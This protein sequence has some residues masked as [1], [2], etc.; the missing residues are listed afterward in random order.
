M[1]LFKYLWAEFAKVFAMCFAGLMTIY[2]VIDFFEKLRRFMKFDAH[3]IDILHY[4]ALRMP[5]I[6][7]QIAP[8]AVLMATLLAFGLLTRNRE[9]TAMRACGVSLL[10]I[11]SPF[12]VF[13]VG[14]SIVL[15][16]MS[17]V[18]IPIA[19]TSAEY[20]RNVTIEKK[21]PTTMKATRPWLQVRGPALLNVDT[22]EVGGRRLQGVRLYRLSPEFRLTGIVEA[23]WADYTEIDSTSGSWTLHDGLE[24]RF[25]PDGT[26]DHRRFDSAPLPL[27]QAPQDFES[28]LVVETESMQLNDLAAYITRLQRDGYSFGRLLTDY[29]AR[30]AF[31][32][33]SV[34]MVCVGIALSLRRMGTR[35]AGIAVG[36]G[37]A[38]LVGFFYWVTHSVAVALGHSGVLAPIMAGWTANLVFLSLGL[39]LLLKVRY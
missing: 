37:Q 31:P 25:R 18:V 34:I 13:G 5:S 21:S 7:F 30:I 10:R 9:I 36:I 1:I 4:F 28:W 12:L 19:A 2:L 39:Y 26:I 22:V 29:H 20:V 3:L 27:S 16:V 23:A 33:V 14:L 38:M 35:G 24:R 15:L 8:L 6:T 32:L 11:A 17:W